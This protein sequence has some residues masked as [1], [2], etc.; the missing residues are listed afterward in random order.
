MRA[1]WPFAARR[2]R[3]RHA[4]YSLESVALELVYI[5]GPVVIVAGIGCGPSARRSRPARRPCW[6]ATSRFSIQRPSRA[7]RP[8]RAR[9]AG[10]A[11]AL[12]ARVRVLVAVF[13]LAGLAVGAVEVVVPA[14]LTPLGDR[15]LTGDA[16]AVGLGSMAGGISA[17]AP[18]PAPPRAAAGAAHG[19]LG[20]DAR[21][22]RAGPRS[23]VAVGLLLSPRA[24]R[25][26]R[27]SSART[28]CS[29]SSRRAGRSP[30]RSRGSRPGLVAGVA[31]GSAAA[32]APSTPTSPAWRSGCA[33]RA[34]SPARGSSP[35]RHAAAGPRP[36]AGGLAG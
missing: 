7:W 17:R 14:I 36:E 16:R 27:R 10:V 2:P 15:D 5:C 6:P 26:R 35:G 33:G 28:A 8:E 21:R 9:E 29:T 34:A 11:G 31:A 32:G 3:P 18:A 22:R 23:P 12:A 25:S 19:R 13:A 20:R 4:A 30:R 24:R 1:L